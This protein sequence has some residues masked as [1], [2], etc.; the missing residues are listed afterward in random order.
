MSA[1][2]VFCQS[3]AMPMADSS[4]Y[5]TDADGK[6]NPDYC[7]YCYQNGAFTADVD[8]N[9]MIEIC[10]PH[11]VA[12]HPEMTEDKAREMMR[13]YLPGLKRWQAKA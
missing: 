4:M 12:G 6:K 11:L 10:V 2:T 8:M 3:C 7:Q 13:Q 9:G 5:G 1:E